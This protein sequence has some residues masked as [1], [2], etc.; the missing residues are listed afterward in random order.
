MMKNGKPKD[1]A[2]QEVPSKADRQAQFRASVAERGLSPEAAVDEAR[3]IPKAMARE[4]RVLR[5]PR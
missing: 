3:L 2:K 4:F 5:W 1:L